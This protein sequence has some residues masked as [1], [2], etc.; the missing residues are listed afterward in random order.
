MGTDLQ[1]L[2][3]EEKIDIGKRQVLAIGITLERV[4]EDY[5]AEKRLCD[6]LK[7]ATGD[8][9]GLVDEFKEILEA[10]REDKAEIKN[11][12]TRQGSQLDDLELMIEEMRRSPN[13]SDP[14]FFEKL[15][16]DIQNLRELKA[17]KV[18]DVTTFIQEI[19]EKLNMRAKITVKAKA[20]K[21]FATQQLAE[22]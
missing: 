3:T 4:E 12:F 19:D 2:V 21:D 8:W 5:N 22:I 16:Q 17:A 13:Y 1:H 11:S 7:E 6:N 20:D 10:L 15:L 18:D 14:L 9:I